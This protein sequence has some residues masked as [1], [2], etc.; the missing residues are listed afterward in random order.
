MSDAMSRIALWL[1]FGSSAA[2]ILGIAASQTLLFLSIVALL[3]SKENLRL[4][5]IKLPLLLFLS[6]TLIAIAFSENPSAGLPQVRKIF[7]FCQLLVVFSLLRNITT[8]RHLV[9]AWAGL[10]TL[11]AGAALFQFNRKVEQAAAAGRDFYSYYVGE[12][13]TGFMSH[14]FTFSVLGMLAL[15]MAMSYLLFAKQTR[16][17]WW[18]LACSVIIA[19]SI[20]LAQTRAVWIATAVAGLYLA[21]FWRRRVLIFAPV[22]LVLGYLV[23]PPAFRTRITSIVRPSQLDSNEFRVVTL[24]T[25]LEMIRQHPIVGL[26]PEV[27]RL[28]FEQFVPNDISRPLPDGSYIHLHNIYLHY[29]AERGIPTLLMFLWLMGKILYD[30]ALGLR[31]LP[32]GRH[33]LRFVLHGGIAV[34][35]ALLVEGFAD[36]NLGDSEVLAMFLAIVGCGYAALETQVPLESNST[37]KRVAA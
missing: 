34:V 18:V 37:A 5:P 6:G 31:K 19:I 32:P 36:V 9:L 12:R 28:K 7:V 26:G 30:F 33:D 13:I 4:P 17:R 10:A 22:I 21:W 2:V 16:S 35:I 27:P 23:S 25:G 3:L 14:W 1:T 24:R 29:A 15:L 20:V 8:I 11:S